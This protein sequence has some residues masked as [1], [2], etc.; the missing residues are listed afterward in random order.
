MS[1]VTEIT[2][3][4]GVKKREF[5]L[6][7]DDQIDYKLVKDFDDYDNFTNLIIDDNNIVLPKNI[8][9]LT[10]DDKF[11]KSLPNL[12]EYPFLTHIT[13]GY[14]FNQPFEHCIPN[15]VTHLTFGYSF[16]Q[17]LKYSTTCVT[18]GIFYHQVTRCYIPNSVTHLTFGIDF[19]QPI[20]GCIPNSVEYLTFYEMN[21]K[22]LYENDIPNTVKNVRFE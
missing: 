22:E 3:L 15:S 21:K 5:Y 14:S 16:N 9:F 13:F 18:L 17:P 8:K 1:H 12:F 19:N 11:N 4:N 20:K 2:P 6:N 7:Y 10:F